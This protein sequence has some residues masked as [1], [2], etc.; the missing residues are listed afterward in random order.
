[1][2][3]SSHLL[4]ELTSI[5]AYIGAARDIVKDGFMP[6]MTALEKRISHLCES[7]QAADF[8]EQSQCLP[9]LAGLLKGLDDCERD[10][11]AWKAAQKQTDAAS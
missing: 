3:S 4:D 6:D 2:S 10:M 7:I 9:A 11:R 8:D 5:K 1:M